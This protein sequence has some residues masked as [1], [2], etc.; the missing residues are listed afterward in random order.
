MAGLQAEE[1]LTIRRDGEPV[2]ATEVAMAHGGRAHL[3]ALDPGRVTVEYGAVV[4]GA[5]LTPEVTE[6]D[7]V[8]YLRPSR[9]AES[10]RLGGGGG[11]GGAGGG[12]GPGAG[13]A[14]GPPGGARGAGAPPSP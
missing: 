3:L 14:P 10:D 4:R 6:A 8:T 1:D 2:K 11:G 7:R 5:A 9:Y 12:G 13:G